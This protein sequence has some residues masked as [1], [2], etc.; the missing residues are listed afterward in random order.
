MNRILLSQ[1]SIFSKENFEKGV[2][3]KGKIEGFN[4][5]EYKLNH[6]FDFEYPERNKKTLRKNLFWCMHILVPNIKYFQE[7]ILGNG[8]DTA[9]YEDIQM[10]ECSPEM[11]A[12]IVRANEESEAYLKNRAPQTFDAEDIK[13]FYDSK[14]FDPDSELMVFHYMSNINGNGKAI[15]DMKKVPIFEKISLM[16]SILNEMR[17]K[18]IGFSSI[19]NEEF[20]YTFKIFED[21]IEKHDE[22][23][24]RLL[25]MM[26]VVPLPTT[27]FI[28]GNNDN[29]SSSQKSTTMTTVEKIDFVYS[30][31]KQK[32]E[33][34]ERENNVREISADEKKKIYCALMLENPYFLENEHLKEIYD[35][36][37]YFQVTL[38]PEQRF[39]VIKAVEQRKNLLITGSAGVGKSH[40]IAV[41]KKKFAYLN[42][43]VALTATTGK[44]SV[45]IDGK[46]L[47]SWGGLGLGIILYLDTF[48]VI[49]IYLFYFIFF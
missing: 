26:A 3:T 21:Y 37:K 10:V 39:C 35:I 41:L 12:N 16:E 19:T 34:F 32:G 8:P 44:A 25:R 45:Q 17:L 5:S 6:K 30:Q 14:F 33:I 20:L 49:S 42:L 4:M 23:Y 15:L 29:S 24:R 40:L 9:L 27:N 2:E 46:T 31:Y 11:I 43:N 28:N 18:N 1:K 13:G 47:H 48:G 22:E 38:S 7:K 36:I